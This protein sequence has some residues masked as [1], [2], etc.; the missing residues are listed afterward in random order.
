MVFRE[1]NKSDSLL[2]DMENNEL[3]RRDKT[4]SLASKTYQSISLSRDL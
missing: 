4:G 2:I 3:E 1:D